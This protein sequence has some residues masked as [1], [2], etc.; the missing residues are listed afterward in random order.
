MAYETVTAANGSGEAREARVAMVLTYTR[1]RPI[2]GPYGAVTGAFRYERAG[3]R[4]HPR[5]PTN[6][7]ASGFS[8]AFDYTVAGHDLDRSGLLLARGPAAPSRDARDAGGLSTR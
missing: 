1:G 6:S 7:P 4:H 5:V 8:S 3:E 2:R